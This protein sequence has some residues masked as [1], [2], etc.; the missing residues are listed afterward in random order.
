[1]VNKEDHAIAVERVNP[2]RFTAMEEAIKNIDTPSLLGYHTPAY[3]NALTEVLNDNPLYL[4]AFF[5]KK[6]AGFL[7]LRWRRG[8]AGIVINGLPFFGPNGGPVL[9]NEGIN[10]ADEVMLQLA[11][12]LNTFASEIGAISVVCYTPFLYNAEVFEQAFS[13]DRAVDK[14]TQYLD[15]QGFTVWPAKIRHKSVGRAK[16]KGVT[17]RMGGQA[18]VPRLLEIYHENYG[19][20]GITLKPD[21]YFHQVV[22][23]LCP[24]GVARFTVA[25]WE[26]RVVACLITIQAGITISYNVPCCEEDAQTAQPNSLLIDESVRTLLSQGYRFWN[27]E[28]SPGRDHPVYK[29]KARWGSQEASYKILIKYP[30][31]KGSFS[32]LRSEDIAREY[33]FYFVI[34]FDDLGN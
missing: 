24:L 19:K 5:G 16:T 12:E 2:D 30:G 4:A 10:H 33:P 1:M 31:G 11:S 34:P 26:N 29:F 8:K 28:S 6:V 21:I 7:P 27:W 32:G 23:E 15:L 20:K 17:V 13:P 25:E 22:E 14:F 3:M 18:D 9:T